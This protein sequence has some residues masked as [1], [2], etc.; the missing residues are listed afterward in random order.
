MQLK[1]IKVIY[2]GIWKV[3]MLVISFVQKKYLKD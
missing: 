2:V 1:V 3:I